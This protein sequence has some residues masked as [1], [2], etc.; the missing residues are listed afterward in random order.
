M[1]ESYRLRRWSLLL[2][3]CTLSAFVLGAC[4][5]TEVSFDPSSAVFK[6]FSGESALKFTRDVT[7]FGP[8][9]PGSEAL[10]RSR[11]WIGK[12]LTDNGWQVQRQVFT[13][14]TPQGAIEFVNLRARFSKQPDESIWTRPTDVLLA[15][16]YDTKYYRDLEFSGAND[17]GSS[18]GALL[19]IARVAAE[20]E[21][22]AERL[23][24]VFFDGEEAFVAYTPSDGLFGSRY[25]ARQYRKWPEAMRFQAGVLLDMVGDRDLN[26]RLPRNSPQELGG[27]LFAAAA[28]LET[29]KYFGNSP[30]EITDDH[31]PLNGAGLPTL[32][33]ID[34][35]YAYWHTSADTVDK[36]SAESLQ[37]VGRTVLL[38]VEKLV[39]ESK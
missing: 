31:V 5:R 19:E 33:V 6:K 28:E 30:K 11:Q 37:I 1:S 4:D 9:P 14:S 20:N 15:S 26:I 13:E 35:D 21:D 12:T 22:F 23:E 38:M 39:T 2:A 29:R 7:D 36:L 34:L 10:E 16:H 3:G 18:I 24:L 17:P 25:Y 27:K 32:D 8:R